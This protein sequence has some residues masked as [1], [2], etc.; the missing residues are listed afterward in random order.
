[1]I[2]RFKLGILLGSWEDCHN[3]EGLAINP[4]DSIQ[5][6]TAFLDGDFV[7]TVKHPTNESLLEYE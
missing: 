3:K 1:M 7:H 6:D 2:E 5:Y 4:P